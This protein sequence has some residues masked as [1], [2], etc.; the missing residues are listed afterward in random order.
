MTGHLGELAFP[1]SS[2]LVTITLRAR[3]HEQRHFWTEA[4]EPKVHVFV[5]DLI[6]IDVLDVVHEWIVLEDTVVVQVRSAKSHNEGPVFVL[7]VTK[8][9]RCT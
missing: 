4:L 6:G 3:S 8:D 5:D 1:D 2:V 7:R 9:H